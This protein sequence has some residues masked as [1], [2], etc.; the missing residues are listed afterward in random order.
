MRKNLLSYHLGAGVPRT[1][2]S[3]EYCNLHIKEDFSE[4]VMLSV[5]EF[6]NDFRVW[7]SKESC[8]FSK[9]CTTSSMEHTSDKIYQKAI[10][11]TRYV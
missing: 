11:R 5:N 1:N 2:I 8:R 9:K 4:N 6:V 3:L 7:A 10:T